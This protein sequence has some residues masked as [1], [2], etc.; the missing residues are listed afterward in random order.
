MSLRFV[1]YQFKVRVVWY[2]NH[3]IWKDLVTESANTLLSQFQ[4]IDWARMASFRP[5]ANNFNTS[6]DLDGGSLTSC[7][8]FFRGNVVFVKRIHKKN[9]DLSREIRKELIHVRIACLSLNTTTLCWTS[10]FYPKV[11]EM[12]H[13]NINPFIGA[14]VETN[15]I[16][17]L[18]LYCDRGNLEVSPV[19]C[20]V[21][22]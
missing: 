22:M 9:I 12:R 13:E 4:G 1:I 2:F 17:I 18:T 10:S 15:N 11:R 14:T 20:G 5:A 8:G 19:F 7:I 6:V 21:V 16:S 3:N